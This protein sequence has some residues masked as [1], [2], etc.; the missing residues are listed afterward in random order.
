MIE[1]G[2]CKLDEN[3]VRYHEAVGDRQRVGP[4]HQRD[5]ACEYL[6]GREGFMRV[7]EGGCWAGGEEGRYGAAVLVP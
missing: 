4:E 5:A 7:H 1:V 3:V 6:V 2:V